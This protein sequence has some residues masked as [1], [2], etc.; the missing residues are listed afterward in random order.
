MEVRSVYKYARI[1]PLKA[2][3]VARE[4]Q[5]MPVSAALD[6]LQYTPKK[7]AVLIEKTLKSAIANAE[8]NHDLDS[9]SLVIRSAMVGEGPSFRRFKPRARGSASPIQKRTAHITIILSDEIELP[10]P[11]QK[12]NKNKPRPK[13][14]PKAAAAP[15]DE[16]E[17]D[18]DADSEVVTDEVA[19]DSA[20]ATTD[21]GAPAAAEEVDVDAE[22]T[23]EPEATSDDEQP[24]D[25]DKA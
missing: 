9:E 21:T 20:D 6:T 23:A 10:E 16:P 19:V 14:R 13:A 15:A 7:S 3:D 25:S 11:K 1:S 24:K 4:I 22:A 17:P 18:T 8:N 12:R 5:G 2:R